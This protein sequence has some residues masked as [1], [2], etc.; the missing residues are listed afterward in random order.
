MAQWDYS[1]KSAGKRVEMELDLSRLRLPEPAEYTGGMGIRIEN[2]G[3]KIQAV[4]INGQPHVAFGERIII[5][6]NLNR[7]ANRIAATLGPGSSQAAHLTYV[8]KRMPFARKKG[9]DL[10]FRL[11]AKSKA[12]FSLYT[13]QPAVL[14]NADWQ[15]WNRKGDH[16]L[17]GHVTSDRTLVL[18][19]AKRAGFGITQAGLPIAGLRETPARISLT[20]E[21]AG[22][23]ANT[24][25][26]R[27][28]RAP[29]RS[30]LGDRPVQV[31]RYGSDFEISLPQF[32]GK[33][34]LHIEF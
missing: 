14:L 18:T 26:F 21:S 31:S 2:T 4:T 15:E 25:R 13:S 3:E 6:P 5:L 7:G 24:L 16:Q 8:S 33:A 17:N 23:D 28:A 30:T 1:W 29:K 9:K 11:L 32:R 34:E 22:G 12:R 20:L 19:R 10:E 27:S